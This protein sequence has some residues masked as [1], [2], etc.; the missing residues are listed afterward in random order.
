M[1]DAVSEL[2]DE[3]IGR[4]IVSVDVKDGGFYINLDNGEGIL[5]F[6]SDDD[7]GD[8]FLIIG[9]VISGKRNLQ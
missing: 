6:I 1:R 8:P 7:S 9:H 3:V 4:T 5:A 2:A